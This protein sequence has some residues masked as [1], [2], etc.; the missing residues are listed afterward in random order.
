MYL[1]LLLLLLLL[2]KFIRCDDDIFELASATTTNESIYC[3]RSGAGGDLH[4]RTATTGGTATVGSLYKTV[5]YR[6]LNNLI[7]VYFL[8]LGVRLII[9]IR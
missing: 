4:I 7:T 8:E 2:F 1:L 3:D 9:F 6:I 5:K